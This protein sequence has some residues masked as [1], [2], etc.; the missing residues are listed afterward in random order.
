M[1]QTSS[2]NASY[3]QQADQLAPSKVSFAQQP[4]YASNYQYG[5]QLGTSQMQSQEKPISASRLN[6]TK[7]Q[8]R[9]SKIELKE[10][11]RS[12]DEGLAQ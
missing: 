9:M 4:S 10:L 11:I 2:Y 8:Q 6:T 7:S 12:I 5:S 1:A 3:G